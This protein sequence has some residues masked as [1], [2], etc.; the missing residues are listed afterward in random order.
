MVSS[1]AAR[2]SSKKHYESN[3]EYYFKKNT[4]QRKRKQQY[5]IDK[6]SVPCKDCGVSYPHYVMEFDHVQDKSYNVNVSLT[7]KQ[8]DSELEKCDVVCANCHATRTYLRR[9][10][11]VE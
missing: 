7:W 5:L 11:V 9:A 2:R 8:I 1:D 10:G 6:K 3:K 4:E